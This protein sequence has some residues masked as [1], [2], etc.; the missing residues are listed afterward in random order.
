MTF[1]EHT[2]IVHLNI[3]NVLQEFSN[4]SMIHCSTN[5]TLNEELIHQP[6]TRLCSAPAE[7]TLT[8]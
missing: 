8:H 1:E 2:H 4:A 5:Y 3:R 6:V 7:S